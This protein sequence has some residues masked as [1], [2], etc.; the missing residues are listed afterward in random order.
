MGGLG[1]NLV[2]F[3]IKWRDDI[4]KKMQNYDPYWAFQAENP[5]LARTVDDVP[6]AISSAH[7][8]RIHTPGAPGKMI[9]YVKGRFIGEGSFGTVHECVNADS[10]KVMAI[11]TL[12]KFKPADEYAWNMLKREVES[13]SRIS[14][15]SA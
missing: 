11:K 6:T 10:G 12:R 3:T 14:H 15:V 13:L 7:M 1:C 9:R 2:Q 5:S 8:T 4:E